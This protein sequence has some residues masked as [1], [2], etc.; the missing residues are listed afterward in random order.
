M[1]NQAELWVEHR[2]E[3]HYQILGSLIRGELKKEKVQR[4]DGGYLGNRINRWWSNRTK[5]PINKLTHSDLKVLILETFRPEDLECIKSIGS[6]ESNVAAVL[7]ENAFSFV[8]K[9]LALLVH[10]VVSEI[11]GIIDIKYPYED[12]K[13]LSPKNNETVTADWGRGLGIIRPHS[14]DLYEAR[15]INV[16]CLTVY[17]DTTSTPT[18]FWLLYDVVNCLTEE[19]LG[20]LCLSQATY[21]SGKNVKGELM[22]VIKPI[23]RR[24]SVEGLG[25]RL[26]FRI[27]DNVGPRMKFSDDSIQNIFS[28]MRLSFKNLKP[29]STNPSTGS[30]S[31]LS[32]YKVLHGRAPLDPVMLY[33]GEASRILFRS[34]GMKER[35]L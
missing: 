13:E 28:K 20:L 17:K 25:L 21:F 9:D 14:D 33:E 5:E 35:Y 11:A 32:N 30:I 22:S 2:F 4:I 16:M 34:K 6:A 23:L 12:H 26:D 19:E 8:D 31:I 7:L 24:D 29:I 1:E 27:D 15:A 18:W 10:E 3:N